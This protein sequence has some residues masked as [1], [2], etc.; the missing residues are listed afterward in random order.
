MSSREVRDLV[1]ELQVLWN[2]LHDRVRRDVEC[3]RRGITVLLICTHR[4]GRGKDKIER[5]PSE[6]FELI[7][8]RDGR[9]IDL[10]TEIIKFANEVGLKY[11][12]TSF[13]KH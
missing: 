11:D 9:L 1:P 2:K 7:V 12:G 5:T 8:L 6:A 10:G 13:S 3:Q 4:D